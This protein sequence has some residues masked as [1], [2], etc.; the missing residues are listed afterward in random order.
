MN[1]NTITAICATAIAVF[2][3]AVS[4]QQARAVREHNRQSVRPLL[5][6]SHSRERGGIMG[7]MIVN[8]GLGP[9]IITGTVL[10]LDGHLLGSWDEATVN[11]FR[12]DFKPRPGATTFI[13]GFTLPAGY[14]DYLLAIDNFD[15]DS[16]SHL[17][18]WKLIRHRLDLEIRYESLYGGERYKAI[19]PKGPVRGPDGRQP[20][21]GFE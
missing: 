20:Q 14:N 13:N 9:A 21:S 12:E 16:D 19:L 15:L 2:S 1:A 3:L 7:I 5:Q 17:E 6:L 4:V 10:K 11:S 18:F 8:C